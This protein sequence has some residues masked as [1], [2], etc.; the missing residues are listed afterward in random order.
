MF[1]PTK[2]FVIRFM[3]TI[4]MTHGHPTATCHPKTVPWLIYLSYLLTVACMSESHENV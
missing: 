4:M 1:L 3:S 2:C